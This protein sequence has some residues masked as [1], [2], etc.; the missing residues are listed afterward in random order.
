MCFASGDLV[1]RND[2]QG[3][4]AQGRLKGYEQQSLAEQEQ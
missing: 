2:F 4:L 3:V 1:A